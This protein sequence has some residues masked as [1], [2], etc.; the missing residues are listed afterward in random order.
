MYQYTDGNLSNFWLANGYE[1]SETPY[2]MA[3]TIPNLPG[4]SRAICKA[5]IRKN[6]KLT[7]AEFRYL[8]QA[9]LMSQA[10]LG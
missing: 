9:M 6:S 8:R 10:S 2:G 1:R 4:L 7:G 5:L 3:I